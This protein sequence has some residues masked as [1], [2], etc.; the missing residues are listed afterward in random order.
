MVKNYLGI[1]ETGR[2]PVRL[3]QLGNDA[4]SIALSALQRLCRYSVDLH[5][6]FVLPITAVTGIVYIHLLAPIIGSLSLSLRCGESLRSDD[7]GFQFG[8]VVPGFLESV[9]HLRS[10]T[11]ASRSSSRHDRPILEHFLALGDLLSCLVG[12][13]LREKVFFVRIDLCKH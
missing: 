13:F 5:V 7:V 3:G 6:L 4:T 9:R 11:L 10:S 1:L 8:S 2:L 12:F